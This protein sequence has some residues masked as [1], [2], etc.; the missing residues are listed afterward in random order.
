VPQPQALACCIPFAR[1]GAR[2]DPRGRVRGPWG[3]PAHGAHAQS[4]K[5]HRIALNTSLQT[6]DPIVT[7]SIAT[8]AFG[9]MVFDPLIARDRK[10]GYRPQMLDGWTI[11]PD[12]TD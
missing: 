7:G 6:L 1:L 2:G 9:Y 8:R 12:R 11:S 5:T 3:I 4:Q 10:G